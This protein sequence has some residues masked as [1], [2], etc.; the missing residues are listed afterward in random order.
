VSR[1]IAL[2]LAGAAFGIAATANSGGY[3]YGVSD[4]AFYTPAVLR[5]IHPDLFP[6]DAPILAVESRLMWSDEI[7][8]ALSRALGADLPPLYLGLYAAGLLALFA[9]SWRFGRAA[10]LST[11]SLVAMLILVTFRHRIAKTGVNSLEGYMHPRML[12][13]ACGIFALAATVA[14]RYGRAAIWTIVSA[15]W[16]P[17]TAFWFAV[18]LAVA[19]VVARPAWR[20]GAFGAAGV[21]ALIGV[22]ALW[23][24]PLAGRLVI[25]DPTWLAVLAEKDY[26]FPHEWPAYAWVANL[27]YALVILLVY[28]KRRSRGVL[29]PG[30]PAFVAGLA[31]LVGIFVLSLPFTMIRVALAVQMQVTRVFWMLDFTAAAYIAWW[32]LDDRLLDR[33][34]GRFL[35]VGLLAAASIGRGAFLISED[36]QLVSMTLPHSP[37]IEAMEWLKGAPPAWYVLADPGHAWKYGASVRLA[38]ERDTLVEAGKDSALAM[39]DRTIALAVADRLSA[40]RDF[41]RL[42]EDDMRALASKYGVDVAVVE[43]SRR[44]SLP[45]LHR[46][47]Q[48]VIYRLR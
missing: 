27:G 46:N 22:W 7:V 15:C 33:R 11:W 45:E 13:F 2:M 43:A 32:L 8:A 17:T 30:E 44:L 41:D 47:S 29:V 37:W 35:V 23:W 38:A 3:R 34:A 21:L 5:D 10:G 25:M 40:L 42:G 20:R 39:Y 28:R 26:L 24:G 9:A 19:V 31:S 1:L 48:F 14:A 4:Q 36:R 18:V 6:H 12:A 16:H